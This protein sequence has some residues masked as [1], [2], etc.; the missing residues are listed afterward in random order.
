MILGRVWCKGVWVRSGVGD[1]THATRRCSR[2]LGRVRL[3]ALHDITPRHGE[4]WGVVSVCHYQDW[5][6]QD[7]PVECSPFPN[8]HIDCWAD[9]CGCISMGRYICTHRV[10][11]KIFHEIPVYSSILPSI[12]FKFQY[13]T[14]P[15][16]KY[17]QVYTI[18]QYAIFQYIPV[19]ICKFLLVM[20]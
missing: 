16:S 15:N 14:Q 1:G 6:L 9:N 8:G 5:G 17:I 13:H 18:F 11:S 4:K 10:A 19:Y 7:F 2:H 12:F 20:H 3:V